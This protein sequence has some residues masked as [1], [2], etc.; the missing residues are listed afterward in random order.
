M[1][2]AFVPQSQEPL[3]P[4]SRIRSESNNSTLPPSFRSV[5]L[6]STKRFFRY[7][8]L[9]LCESVPRFDDYSFYYDEY[10]DMEE[11][12]EES[13]QVSKKMSNVDEVD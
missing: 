13:D 1:M 2:K 5:Y 10:L 4:F 8:G 3:S 12:W 11:C 7:N 9:L 6:D